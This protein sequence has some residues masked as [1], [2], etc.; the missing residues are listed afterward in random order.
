M[1]TPDF[2]LVSEITNVYFLAGAVSSGASSGSNGVSQ[3][4]HRTITVTDGYY[5]VAYRSTND[6]NTNNPHNFKWQIELGNY[7]TSW[8]PYENICPISGRTGL[9]VYVSPTTSQADATTHAVDWTTEAGTVYGGTLNVVTGVLTVDRAMF[10][11]DN[12]IN[13]YLSSETSDVA[14]FDAHLAYNNMPNHAAT[15]SVISNRF[16]TAI[17]SGT[18]GRVVMTGQQLYFVIAKS[19]LSSY[20]KEGARAWLNDNPS[21]FLYK[22]ATP[23]TYQLT[24]QEVQMLLGENYVWSSS[25][26]TV[27]VTYYA[28]GNANPLQSL[29]ILLGGNYS[30]P[31]TADDVSDKEALEIILGGNK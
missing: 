29:N 16:S 15:P 2:P 14:V 24:P 22:I 19:Q 6:I 8:T 1:S 7:A 20:D 31:K 10:N 18:A 23:L 17:G 3:S 26:D 25:G 5:T 21:Q 9:S 4:T 11:A 30:N 13:C 27:S 28:E 12:T